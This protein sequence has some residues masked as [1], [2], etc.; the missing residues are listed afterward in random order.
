MT[1]S[2]PTTR[3]TEP[4][5]QRDDG[6]VV[7]PIA[8]IGMAARTAGAGS[9]E[10]L[11]AMLMDGVE[12]RTEFTVEDQ[13]RAGVD[14]E[15]A[16]DP[17][18]VPAAF[19]VDR[20]DEFDPG[21]FGMTGR[22]AELSDPQQRLM[23]EIAH[24]ALEDAG[25]DP[26]RH[27]GEV[28]V[29][30][31]GGSSVYGWLHLQM[32]PD[33]LD[34]AG[35]LSLSVGNSSDYLATN[36]S[37]NLNLMGPSMTVTTACSTSLVATHLAVEALRNHECDV[38]LA[39]G[40][41]VELPHAAGYVSQD[42]YTSPTGHLRPFDADARGTM[43]GS[44][45]GAVVLKRLAD[46]VADGDTVRAVI[47]GNAVNNDGATKV[48][49]S[50][51]SVAGQVAVI[52]QALD[53]SGI[54]P[55]TIGYVE[56]HGTGT[57]LGDP[58][59]VESL[60][61]AF[62]ERVDGQGQWCAIGSVKGNIGH[63]S[64][65]S[66]VISLIKAA[67]VLERGMI[68]PSINFSRPNPVIDFDASP[69]FVAA[70]ASVFESGQT[71]RRA[72]VSSFGIGGT[73][74]HLVLE[75]APDPAP[76]TA[77]DGHA[78]VLRLS[79]HTATAV[80][81][82][83]RE[84]ADHLES[85]NDVDL[86]NVATTLQEG[87]AERTHRAAVTATTTGEAV[88]ALRRRLRPTDTGAGVPALALLFSGQG[89]QFPGMAAGLYGVDEHFTR[90]LDACVADATEVLDEDVLA[91][92]TQPDVLDG[93]ARL[94]ATRV[95]QPALF[96]LEYALA[97][98]WIEGY[99]LEPQ[100]LI[101]HSIGEYVAATVAGVFHPRDAMHLVVTRGALMQSMPTG[102][103]V[104]V[105][106][107]E[108]AVRGL[109]TP[110]VEIATVNG[111]G[112]CVVG[113]PEEAINDFTA[114]LGE[115]GITAR[116]L[117]TSHAFHTAAMEPIL[118]EFAAA[119]GRVRRRTPQIPVISNLTGQPLSPQQA[120][121]PEYWADQLRHAVRF[122]D[123]VATVLATGPI[124]FLECGPGRQLA[125]LARMQTRGGLAPATSLPA[126]GEDDAASSV[127]GAATAALW[128]AGLT[129]RTQAG[130]RRIPLPTYPFE[131]SR[132]FIERTTSTV[133]PAAG[134]A[135]QAVTRGPLSELD[136]FFALPTWASTPPTVAAG[137]D[138]F[139]IVVLGGDPPGDLVAALR[140]RGHRVQEADDA[141]SAARLVKDLPGLARVLY[142]GAL[143]GE[144][145]SL[146][147][148][149]GEEGLLQ[150]LTLLQE[151]GPR[152]E[153]P[154]HLDLVSA[155]VDAVTG[156]E[157]I[158]PA[159]ALLAGIARVAPLEVSGL[160][161]RWISVGE[162]TSTSA[163]VAELEQQPETAEV[164]LHGRRR[165]G[166]DFAQVRP[167]PDGPAARCDADGRY[168]ITGG[169]GGIGIT[170]AEDLAARHGSQGTTARLLLLARTPL[171]PRETW[172][173]LADVDATAA[174]SAEERAA[175][176]VSAIRRMQGHGAEV[177]VLAVDSTDVEAMREAVR[178]A[179]QA[180]GGL[181]GVVHAAGVP[182]GGMVEVKQSDAVRI[183]LAPKVLG[184]L[185]L[186]DAL[187]EVEPQW[188]LLC[189]S[190]TAVTGDV[191]Q[192]DYCSAN[193]Y[194]DAQAQAGGWS[195]PVVSVNWGGWS[196]VGMAVETPR[197]SDPADA[198][199][200]QVSPADG[201]TA[202]PDG[203]DTRDLTHP[204]LQTVSVNGTGRWAS[205]QIGADRDGVL[206]VHRNGKDR[207]LPGTGLVE[208]A[209]AAFEACFTAPSPEHR[210]QLR[211]VAFLEP[212]RVPD[213]QRAR[214]TVRFED[215]GDGLQDFSV[216]SELGGN[217]RLHSQGTAA[218]VD[219]PRP[220]ALDP[221][222]LSAGTEKD[223]SEQQLF[224]AE[225]RTSL[226][227]FGPRWA[228]LEQQW[229]RDGGETARI[230]A[231]ETARDEGWVLHPA[232]LD[233]A[234]AFSDRGEGSYLPIGYGE[235]TV[236]QELPDEFYSVLTYRGADTG[237]MISADLLMVDPQ[238]APLVSI[239]DFALRRI[240]AE[241]VTSG[242]RPGDGEPVMPATETVTPHP[243]PVDG[244]QALPDSAEQALPDSVELVTTAT[245]GRLTPAQGAAALQQVLDHRESWGGQVVVNAW[246]IAEAFTRVRSDSPAAGQAGAEGT[247]T[248]VEVD[249]LVPT[250]AGIWS[251]VLGVENVGPD[252]DFF[253]LGGNSL[254]AV[255]LIG[256]V[257]KAVG[258]R[259]PMR[260]LFDA[261]TVADMADHVLAVREAQ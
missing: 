28:G 81:T 77:Q 38:A 84:L 144:N 131:R 128:Q 115:Q 97:Q 196:G 206:A 105:P 12:A 120:L 163:L 124:Q 55:R 24:T 107:D 201:S 41:S 240:D 47:R 198:T 205:A 149:Q 54:D 233:V 179:Q 17:E 223:L 95:T 227:K 166:K 6:A 73:N 117:R 173:Q 260:A 27:D 88:Q 254:V 248:T 255:Q 52:G 132:Y 229:I 261:P 82:M 182:G 130:G 21:A 89:S 245:P 116:A 110:G 178:H 86:A 188:I 129:V 159:A 25:I 119:V 14:P 56:T 65:A 7:E 136:E 259:L 186:K 64:Q 244:E 37:Y 57:P 133:A 4:H 210:V 172:D 161:V 53:V 35:A 72:G 122:G 207:V 195:G 249:G 204:I 189:S 191:G 33:V 49:F 222:V 192:V 61:R 23:L 10:E 101:G 199:A 87:R 200:P 127:V 197:V 194:L 153:Q 60:T 187:T 181:D 236:H 74:A 19:V 147:A 150:L 158:E 218:W 48:G 70:N 142:A 168:L 238:G 230:V 257:R 184:T 221:E 151:V 118:Q 3:G 5:D 202:A 214:V 2:T 36:I 98:M 243:Q 148:V 69:F 103:M 123:A 167:G 1:T 176:T 46:A 111:P 171:P 62:R 155:P 135:P 232:M 63:L 96:A 251:E 212:L 13:I 235:I 220:T 165:W 138:A 239:G 219:T 79:G 94:R 75:Q 250:I 146:T 174:T 125:G 59:E 68:P 183:V 91:L 237:E 217:E 76:R 160:T 256:Q 85:H 58:I 40:S 113:G 108:E 102:V 228:A 16:R 156:A 112:A 231:P 126:P 114:R 258:V 67:L 134:A 140:D 31:G 193:A 242:R 43:W 11:W 32:N 170:V 164:A 226:E 15:E 34:T 225:G 180:W 45:A 26:P 50:A 78:K 208:M 241:A 224:R 215:G 100:W 169:T 137:V 209:R 203:V 252:D 139:D 152:D 213:G 83:A 29:Y 216:R 190:I 246:D 104:A 106:L 157:R 42:G 141:S 175:R 234:T 9:V 8:I 109:L 30:V 20:Y 44:G 99:G 80:Q 51:P 211:D 39:G 93:E 18:F 154:L 92:L 143:E 71:P 66:G 121:D 185:A 145:E 90:A 247:N 253:A 22:E 177:E 162:A